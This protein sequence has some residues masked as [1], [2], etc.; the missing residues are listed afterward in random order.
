MTHSTDS[1]LDF[2]HFYTGSLFCLGFL[3][4]TDLQ[5]CNRW[6]ALL[7]NVFGTEKNS[8][9]ANCRYSC[10]LGILADQLLTAWGR[11]T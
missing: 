6:I 11:D 8:Q 9:G 4:N 7:A 3:V 2:H 5:I 10:L 1:M